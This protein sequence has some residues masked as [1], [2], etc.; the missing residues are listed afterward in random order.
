MG[1]REILRRSDPVRGSLLLRNGLLFNLVVGRLRQNLI[2]HQVILP[3][4]YGRLSMSF[5]A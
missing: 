5:F 1:S 3:L 2:L 4:L